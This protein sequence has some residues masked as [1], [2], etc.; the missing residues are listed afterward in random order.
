MQQN[1]Y[2]LSKSSLVFF[3][4]Y[5]NKSSRSFHHSFSTIDHMKKFIIPILQMR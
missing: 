5:M 4:Y 2:V 1:T 3:L